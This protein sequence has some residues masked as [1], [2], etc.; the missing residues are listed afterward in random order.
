MNVHI[1]SIYE[2]Q[3]KLPLDKTHAGKDLKVLLLGMKGSGNDLKPVV[4]LTA[5]EIPFR[6]VK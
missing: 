2:F 5:R 4:W 3:N 1:E 6:E